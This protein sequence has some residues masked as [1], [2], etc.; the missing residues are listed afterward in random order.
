MGNQIDEHFLQIIYQQDLAD[1]AEDINHYLQAEDTSAA[2]LD[3]AYH[4]WLH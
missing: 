2:M 4:F 1:W 3:T